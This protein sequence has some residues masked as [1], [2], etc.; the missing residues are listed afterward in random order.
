MPPRHYHLTLHA[1]CSEQMQASKAREWALHVGEKG[2]GCQQT[3]PV[4]YLTVGMAR[5]LSLL[6]SILI[7]VQVSLIMGAF[8]PNHVYHSL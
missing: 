7:S 2:R 3:G 6:Y 5:G 4:Y 1:L 8:E